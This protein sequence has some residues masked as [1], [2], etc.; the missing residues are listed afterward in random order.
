MSDSR[1]TATLQPPRSGSPIVRCAN[2]AKV[3]VVGPQ[4]QVA[5]VC[6]LHARA[7]PYRFWGR[8]V[9]R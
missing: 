9:E 5:Q 1:C 6:G 3:R 2:P 8:V 7:L 4:G